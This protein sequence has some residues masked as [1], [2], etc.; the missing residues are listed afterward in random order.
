M[1]RICALFFT[2]GV[3]LLLVA[4]HWSVFQL[5]DLQCMEPCCGC[6]HLMSARCTLRLPS[7]LANDRPLRCDPNPCVLS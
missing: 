3:L 2:P 5:C 6:F 7:N 4:N 1:C